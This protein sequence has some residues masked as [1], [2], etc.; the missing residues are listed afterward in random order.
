MELR[1]YVDEKEWYAEQL[2]F[3]STKILELLDINV[4]SCTCIPVDSGISKELLGEG[5]SKI[6]EAMSDFN[7][8][9]DIKVMFIDTSNQP[10]LPNIMYSFYKKQ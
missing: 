4:L 3:M 8:S 2:E 6:L 5:N 9:H 10:Q 7:K 1:E